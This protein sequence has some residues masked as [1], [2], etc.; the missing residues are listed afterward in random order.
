MLILL[1]SQ[2]STNWLELQQKEVE[3]HKS[4]R[5]ENYNSVE[6]EKQMPHRSTTG[7]FIKW[8][9]QKTSLNIYSERWLWEA[10]LLV[11]LAKK[12]PYLKITDKKKRLR[13]VKQH[14]HWNR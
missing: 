14:R 11:R 6:S 13:W 9:P 8:D 2:S 3:G 7:S 1:L 10:A 4:A 12:K 5:R